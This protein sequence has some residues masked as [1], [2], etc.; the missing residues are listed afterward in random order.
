MQ[1]TAISVPARRVISRE[2]RRRKAKRR[3]QRWAAIVLLWVIEVFI[4][5]LAGLVPALLVAMPVALARS[6]PALG[7]EWLLVFMVT[8]TAYHFIHRAIFKKLEEG[9]E[10]DARNKNNLPVRKVQQGTEKP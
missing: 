8:V 7:G 1:T 6:E 9:G 3:I 4:A 5:S 10:Q 2:K